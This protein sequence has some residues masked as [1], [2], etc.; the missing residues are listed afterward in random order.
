MIV[1]VH[2]AAHMFSSGQTEQRLCEN[3]LIWQMLFIDFVEL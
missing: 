3:L 2:L 1:I